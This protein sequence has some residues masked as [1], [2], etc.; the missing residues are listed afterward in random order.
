MKTWRLKDLV[1]IDD[2]VYCVVTIKGD[3]KQYVWLLVVDDFGPLL[4]P[5]LGVF[6]MA[7]ILFGLLFAAK[8]FGADGDKLKFVGCV[9]GLDGGLGIH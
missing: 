3:V 8:S 7:N 2:V 1:L 4:G 9:F 5:Q 6:S